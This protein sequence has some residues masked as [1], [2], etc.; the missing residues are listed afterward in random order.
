MCLAVCE[1]CECVAV[2]LCVPVV[3]LCAFARL[4]LSLCFCVS[5][6]VC[7]CL[8]VR[9]CAS[10]AV[11]VRCV[12]V[13]VPMM[14]LPAPSTHTH[15]L[16]QVVGVELVESAV[17]DARANAAAN[18]VTNATFIAGAA[19]TVLPG[20]TSGCT[21]RVVAVVDPPRS[22]LHAVSASVRLCLCVS[23]PIAVMSGCVRVACMLST[24]PCCVECVRGSWAR[25]CLHLPDD[26]MVL[27]SPHAAH[28]LPLPSPRRR[29]SRP[30]GPVA[31]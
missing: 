17:V 21:G 27:L 30:F 22:G 6:Y 28:P 3:R 20:V 4:S 18:G 19:E 13:Y 26:S 8:S 1:L 29:S 25:D 11:C 9:V 16:S 15:K 2:C 23:L 24:S 14:C 12:C 31:T 5:V 10:V 7:L